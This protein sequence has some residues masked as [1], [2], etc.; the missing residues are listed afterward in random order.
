VRLLA[1][2]LHVLGVVVWLGGLVGQAH[3][4][5]P[6]ARAGQTAWVAEAAR[7]ARPVAWTALA[8]VV[9]TGLYNVTQLGPLEHVMASG[10]ALTLA[11]K[12]VLVLV[13]IALSGHRDFA[14]VPRLRRALAAGGDPAPAL[15]AIVRLDRLVIGLGVV[16]VYL[17]VAVSRP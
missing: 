3:L 2:W 6:S 14:Q 15:R 5:P 10:A 8:V 17:G 1:L 7:R 9:L 16:I 12:F 11:G 4:L 13:V